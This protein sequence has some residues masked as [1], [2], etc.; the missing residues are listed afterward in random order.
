MLGF[1]EHKEKLPAITGDA[2]NAFSTFSNATE[3]GVKVKKEKHYLQ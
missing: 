2:I 1:E 3:V